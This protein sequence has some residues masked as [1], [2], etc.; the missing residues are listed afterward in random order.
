MKPLR[1]PLWLA[2]ICGLGVLL[3]GAGQAKS[4]DPETPDNV[5]AGVGLQV[6]PTV[7][8]ELVVLAVVE[9]SPAAAA[10]ILPGDLIIAV[11]G[12]ALRGKEFA[13]VVT[14]YLWGPAG[15]ATVLTLMRPGR[16]G[17]EEKKIER[18]VLKGAGATNLPGVEMLVPG[19]KGSGA[20]E[21]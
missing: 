20:A 21:N 9:A 6:V 18:V 3:V 8:G 19:G 11:D 10:G 1:W 2:L 4:A 12:H 13:D 17:Q 15:S 14:R 7:L 16:A 5:V